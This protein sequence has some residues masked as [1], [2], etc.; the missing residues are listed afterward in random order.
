MKLMIREK[1]KNSIKKSIKELQKKKKLLDF[2][3]PEIEIEHPER[4]SYGDY[5]SNI[6]ILIGKQ[7]KKNPLEIANVLSS[8]LKSKLFAKVEVKKPGFIN[9][10][11]S[12]LFLENQV[13]EILKEK[14]K[15]GNLKIGRDK[16]IQ[17]E[18]IS[19]NPTG[20][21]TIGNARGG[22]FGDVL[23]NVLKK[24]G[25]RVEKAYYINDHGMQVLALGHSVLKDKEAK[26]RGEYID[27]LH[28]KIKGKDPYKVGQMAAKIIVKEMIRKTTDKMGIKYDEWFSETELY[29]SKK[30]DK[31]LELLKRKKLIYEKEGAWWFKS[32]KYGDKRDRVVI[33]ADG[34][35][36]YLAG[37][38]AYHKYK[39][40]QKRFDKVIN[41]WGA[42]HYG[43]VSGLQAGVKALGH[44]GKLDII[45]LQFVTILEKGE[46]KRMSKRRGI[47]ITMDE[48][49][50]QVGPDVVRFLFLQK[51]AGTHLNFDL[52]LAKEQSEKN[53]VYYVQYANARIESILRKSKK[54][55]KDGNLK[56]LHHPSELALIKELVRFPEIVADTAKDYQVQRLPQYA[57]D[58]ATSFHRFYR[59]CKVLSEDEDLKKAR[60]SLI[61]ATKIV[62]KNTLDLMGISVPEKM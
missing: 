34:Q 23:A 50:K 53:P 56:L 36:T 35:K 43:D 9:F 48:L 1:I 30:V 44:P 18:F 20:P 16:K 38:L 42:D 37:D 8:R 29:K 5:A 12:E 52:S 13:K 41:I 60:L 49:L 51:S 2:T 22:P 24:A 4:K 26:Y 10:F 7:T 62:I 21:L 11:L 47:F 25:F 46:K 33:K 55:I 28:K 6:A 32:S 45:L 3:L 31:V 27:Y 17:V 15:F 61:S 59:D 40:E 57:I 39:F 14:G 19:A 54:E 58:L